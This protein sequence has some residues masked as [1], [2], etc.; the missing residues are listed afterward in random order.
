MAVDFVVCLRGVDEPETIAP[1]GDDMN[2]GSFTRTT[3][4]VGRDDIFAIEDS[5]AVDETA[6]G[7]WF[8]AV[9]IRRHVFLEKRS[10]SLVVPVR[11]DD[12]ALLVVGMKKGV[13]RRWIPND[14]CAY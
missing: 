14:E 1:V 8:M 12:I 13:C 3:R 2:G 4:Q 6:V 10:C 5:F 11:Q 7:Y 9:A